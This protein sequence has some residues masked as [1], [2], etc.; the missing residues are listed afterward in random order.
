MNA[1]LIQHSRTGNCFLPARLWVTLSILGLAVAMS[2]VASIATAAPPF[3]KP[4]SVQELGDRYW[5]MY[6]TRFPM[7]TGVLSPDCG[8]PALEDLS[9]AANRKWQDD[10]NGLLKDVRRIPK[11]TLSADDLLSL[12]LLERCIRDE[13]LRAGLPMALVPL[14]PISGPLAELTTLTPEPGC[15]EQF[16]SRLKSFPKQIADL[17]A[18]L[19]STARSGYVLPCLLVEKVLPQIDLTKNGRQILDE[20]RA[21]GH[22]HSP[23]GS[24]RIL[25][26]PE[27][28]ISR[29]TVLYV[30]PALRSLHAYLLDEYTPLCRDS[31]GLSAVPGGADIYSAV[32]RLRV[33][34]PIAP[35]KAHERGLN[36]VRW[37]DEALSK[38]SNDAQLEAR[39]RTELGRV[40]DLL[41][42]DPCCI[43]LNQ[44][45]KIRDEAR[46]ASRYGFRWYAEA[47][48]LQEIS[49][50]DGDIGRIRFL[51]RNL[52]SAAL[53]VIDTG[54]HAKGW[55]YDQAVSY[56][57][58]NTAR[59]DAQIESDVIHS[60]SFPGEAA[61]AEISRQRFNEF[62]SEAEVMLGDRFDLS[63]F[64]TALRTEGP[65][66]LD[67]LESRMRA[68]VE[69][70]AK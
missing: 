4:Q 62:L 35:D 65:M 29:A 33:T 38:Y 22:D 42:Q 21:V 8:P 52:Y 60:V 1:R 17:Q 59:T 37:Q 50:A 26:P 54:I 28:P 7:R 51:Q 24:R 67:M 23:E 63:K 10:L 3:Q 69:S 64:R 43:P 36:E 30:E 61:A 55:S 11:G 31:I 41:F 9:P 40:L 18:N 47:K 20:L 58:E 56:L 49:L 2:A 57:K 5:S 32:L 45:G 14:T 19:H 6:S 27:S 66:P 46:F 48:C 15:E 53:L 39:E 70:Q 44:A 34:F 16:I 12:D 25:S 68:W 13:I